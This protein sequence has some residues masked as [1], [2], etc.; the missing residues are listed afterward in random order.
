[1][2]SADLALTQK[3]G[4]IQ[5]SE[6]ASQDRVVA[7]QVQLTNIIYNLIEKAIKYCDWPPDI[8]IGSKSAN[9][10]LEISISDNGKG[11]GQK[12]QPM[13]FRKFYRVPTGNVHDVKGFG[14]GLYYVKMVI[15]GH[16]GVVSVDSSPEG[17]TFTI[18]LPLSHG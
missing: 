3:C 17:S 1:I 2:Q 4:K 9:G 11:I 18:T 16:G 13:I 8:R 5:F 14:L 15:E 6:R 7:D 10:L 12:E